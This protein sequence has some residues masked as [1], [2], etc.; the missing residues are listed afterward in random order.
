M[1]V[2]QK[3][4]IIL[5]FLILFTQTMWIGYT[6][7]FEPRGS[8]FDKYNDPKRAEI[9]N[10]QSLDELSRRY[11]E[12]HKKVEVAKQER[13]KL[14]EGK[15]YTNEL[16]TE[17]YKSEN[18]LSY[19][20]RDWEDKN[21]E[22]HTLRFYGGI[23]FCLILLGTFLFKKGYKW[24]GLTMLIT[25]YSEIIIWVYPS[26]LSGSTYAFEHLMI[27]KIIFSTVSLILLLVIT[28]TL[29]FFGENNQ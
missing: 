13:E 2:L 26:T 7:W 8:V 29:Q 15:S 1:K 11:D 14:T 19:A 12:A 24:Y 10:T 17:P 5:A 4:F 21:K 18:M 3:T 28:Q 27:N 6:L 25:A 20:I 22:I 23:S 9:N 16:E